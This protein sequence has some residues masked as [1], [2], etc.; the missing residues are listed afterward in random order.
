MKNGRKKLKTEEM[1]QN[2]PLNR[3]WFFFQFIGPEGR[4]HLDA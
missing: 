3:V 1:I 4:Y 2:E